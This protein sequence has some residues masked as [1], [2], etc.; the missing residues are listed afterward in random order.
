MA[1]RLADFYPRYYH[2]AVWFVVVIQ[3]FILAVVYGIAW[4]AT[5]YS[6]IGP[7]YITELIIGSVFLIEL[8]IAPLLIKRLIEPTKLLSEAITHVSKQANDVTPPNI[9]RARYER[10][11]LKSMIQTIYELSVGSTHELGVANNQIDSL[12]MN[13][14]FAQDLLKDLPCGVMALNKER[15]VVFANAKAPVVVGHDQNQQIE[16]I[17]NDDELNKWLKTCEESK[18]SDLSIWT[19]I[20]DKL[21]DEPQRRI[22]DVIA[23]YQKEST[24]SD[25]IIVTVDK[26]KEYAIAQEDMDF[27]ALAAHELRG[28]ITVIRGYLD[29]LSMEID[30]KLLPE[31]KE[32]FERLS[33]SSNRLSSYI[34]NILNVSRYDRKH[35]KLHLHEETLAAIFQSLADDLGMRARTQ[36]RLLSINIPGDLPT[37][38]ADN[39]SLSEV[40]GNL[41]DNAIKYSFEGSQIIVNATVKGDFVE[42]SVQDS[43]IGIP[44]T[45]MSHLFTKF[46]RSHRSR[47]TVSGTGLGLYISKAIIE[48]HGGQIWARSKEGQGSTFGFSVPIYATV[49]NK[50]LA[51]NN[52]NQDIIE[53]SSGWIKNHSMTRG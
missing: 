28:P 47:Q 19:R 36:N 21:P 45:I 53:S 14:A 7:E 13:A 35:L 38:A 22:F 6:L 8:L 49:A 3:A 33:V 17:F 43:G 30:S 26:T 16:L 23:L 18:M 27:I 12:R 15:A 5:T 2:K 24:S 29:V 44:G 31:Q 39:N 9:N 51:S 46:Y 11:G 52:G 37:V 10:S 50:L 48:S 25:T 41:V 20:P 34:N 4:S 42:V 40:I 32:L 1:V